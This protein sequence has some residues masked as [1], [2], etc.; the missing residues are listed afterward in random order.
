MGCG[1]SETPVHPEPPEP[2]PLPSSSPAP[3]KQSP[4][5]TFSPKAPTWLRRNFF[6]SRKAT[7][8]EPRKPIPEHQRCQGAK[9]RPL[10]TSVWKLPSW[11]TSFQKPTRAICPHSCTGSGHGSRAPSASAPRLQCSLAPLSGAQLQ[12]KHVGLIS[13][14]SHLGHVLCGVPQ[15]VRSWRRTGFTPMRCGEH[16]P[17]GRD[18]VDRADSTG[19]M[20]ALHCSGEGETKA[21]RAGPEQGA[22]ETGSRASP[23]VTRAEM[24]LGEPT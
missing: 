21:A 20:G 23:A 11:R 7:E 2:T 5:L 24:G 9:E 15:P 4:H 12:K 8:E 16:R 6:C 1:Q 10:R 22:G 3:T 17:R 14:S 18:C 19:G 13:A